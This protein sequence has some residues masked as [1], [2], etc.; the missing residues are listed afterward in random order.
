MPRLR[1][2][3]P[4][5]DRYDISDGDWVEIKRQLTAEEEK[6]LQTAG[7]RHMSNVREGAAADAQIAVDWKAYGLAR[8]NTYLTD[9]SFQDDRGKQVP[10][11][12]DAIAAL[13]PDTYDE[14]ETVI[15][16]HRERLEA[17]KNVKRA[18]ETPTG[19]GSAPESTSPDSLVAATAT[20]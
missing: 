3:Q 18:T 7:L 15:T 20:P 10:V 5:R 9:W 11:T 1:F 16:K 19:S 14:I 4:H 8:V 12:V 13:D 2:V 17:E 6:F